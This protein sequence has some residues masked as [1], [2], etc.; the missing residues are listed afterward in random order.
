M[1]RI[2]VIETFGQVFLFNEENAL[3]K[4]LVY[5]LMQSVG[6]FLP[7]EEGERGEWLELESV[8][9][10]ISYQIIE[11]DPSNWRGNNTGF[12]IQVR[13][14]GLDQLQRE[15]DRFLC[16]GTVPEILLVGFSFEDGMTLAERAWERNPRLRKIPPVR[17][18][19]EKTG[20]SL[21]LIFPKPGRTWR[22]L[23]LVVIGKAPGEEPRI[24]T[25]PL[26]P[27]VMDGTE[28]KKFDRLINGNLGG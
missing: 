13:Q 25:K 23:E 16:W 2:T 5:R 3:T 17:V 21:R 7:P 15:I 24:T 6:W 11:E 10:R 8:G 22:Q 28:E 12:S 9:N 1:K 4:T 19:E 20:M 14:I 26:V 27:S 18:W